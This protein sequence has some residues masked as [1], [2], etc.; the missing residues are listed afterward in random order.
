MHNL[1]FS[2]VLGLMVALLSQSAFG[3]N[4]GPY[5][6]GMSASEARK[7]GIGECQPDTRNR[8][9]CNVSHELT[10]LNG[11]REARI[12]FDSNRRIVEMSVVI[13]AASE[14]AVLPNL[15]MGACP[16]NWSNG[17]WCYK[18]PDLVRRVWHDSSKGCN[19]RRWCKGAEPLRIHVNHDRA[20]V[21]SFAKQRARRT[22]EEREVAAIQGK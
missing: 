2:T 13:D 1:K 12:W 8:V 6:L 3:F 4:V 10:V 16:A 14:G 22:R 15:D 21:D 9:V 11:A 17:P 18:S 20:F 19:D 5:R 7:I